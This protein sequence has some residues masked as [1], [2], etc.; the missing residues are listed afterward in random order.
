MEAIQYFKKKAE[1]LGKY[2]A[3][4]KIT[5][6]FGGNSDAYNG[7]YFKNCY[8]KQ[9]KSYWYNRPKY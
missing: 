5:L 6:V 3:N 7:H 1:D 8:E 2:L 4:N 9:W